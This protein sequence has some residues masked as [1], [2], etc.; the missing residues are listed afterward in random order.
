M[1]NGSCNGSSPVVALEWVSLRMIKGLVTVPGFWGPRSCAST[2]PAGVKPMAPTEHDC[3]ASF[4]QC[5][6][7]EDSVLVCHCV[8]RTGARWCLAQLSRFAAAFV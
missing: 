8:E 5:W 1:L 2:W 4:V 3:W 6:A 7:A